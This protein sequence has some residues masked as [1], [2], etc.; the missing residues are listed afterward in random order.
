MC[1]IHRTWWHIANDNKSKWTLSYST[2]NNNYLE[3]WFSR[4]FTV[5]NCKVCSIATSIIPIW[6][7]VSLA[8]ISISLNIS[9]IIYNFQFTLCLFSA[10]S[11]LVTFR[12]YIL[13]WAIYLSFFLVPS[14]SNIFF[15]ITGSLSEI[16]LKNTGRA[17]STKDIT[18]RISHFL[19]KSI[20]FK[21]LNMRS[22]CFDSLSYFWLCT[23]SKFRYTVLLNLTWFFTN[24]SGTS[25]FIMWSPTI[26]S[27]RVG[28]RSRK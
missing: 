19:C 11:T 6:M 24:F 7:L 18:A 10:N 26:T 16:I 25:L 21:Y 28:D 1:W 13:S 15:I 3:T 22:F 27:F 8:K 20:T 17:F 4:E 14:T 5:I 9:W 23:N 2:D 12:I